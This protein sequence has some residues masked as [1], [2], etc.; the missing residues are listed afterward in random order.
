MNLLLS[1][2]LCTQW[3]AI[4]SLRAIVNREKAS[5][6]W[7]DKDGNIRVDVIRNRRLY[8]YIISEQGNIDEIKGP[9]IPDGTTLFYNHWFYNFVFNNPFVQLSPFEDGMV[10]LSKRGG[11]LDSRADF[12][13][14]EYKVDR[15]NR[16]ITY[17]RTII[18]PGKELYELKLGT[19]YIT[20]IPGVPL[21]AHLV[22]LGKDYVLLLLGGYHKSYV[23]KPLPNAFIEPELPSASNAL[24][25]IL[26]KLTKKRKKV[27]N[28]EIYK[29]IPITDSKG[30][31]YYVK[32][33]DRK[34][35]DL[36]YITFNPFI[37]LLVRIHLANT[38]KGMKIERFPIGQ[39]KDMLK[40]DKSV[41]KVTDKYL[42]YFASY[43]DLPVLTPCNSTGILNVS[44]D[45]LVF[46]FP[47]PR[48]QSYIGRAVLEHGK[49]KTIEP[50]TNINAMELDYKDIK[51]KY[52]RVGFNFVNPKVINK[53]IIKHRYIRLLPTSEV[54]LK[55][56]PVQDLYLYVYLLTPNG[57]FYHKKFKL[58]HLTDKL[59]EELLHHHKNNIRKGKP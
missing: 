26:F 47:S 20:F 4:D 27:F 53:E 29:K 51:E 55:A 21:I 40:A 2:L 59:S 6:F 50:I 45:T 32:G 1:I 34:N 18:L 23:P 24:Y 9:E 10:L 58:L 38:I 7:M 41:L 35:N 8:H 44:N 11:F 25:L 14:Y 12:P 39:Y 42:P 33:R 48:G 15:K 19:E 43:C 57:T 36:Y 5:E 31:A 52:N 22:W 46:F 30:E 16:R 3:V 28:A 13:I 17:K 54:L 49:L 56:I 37:D